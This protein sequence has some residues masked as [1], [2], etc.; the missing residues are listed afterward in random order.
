MSQYILIR[1]GGNISMHQYILIRRVESRRAGEQESRRAGEQESRRGQQ[2]AG[3]KDLYS[4]QLDQYIKKINPE[5]LIVYR[6]RIG[7][8]S[9]NYHNG[10]G[11]G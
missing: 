1:R 4:N 7:R 8:I 2:E 11:N 3:H 5:I 9:V 10:V 6:K